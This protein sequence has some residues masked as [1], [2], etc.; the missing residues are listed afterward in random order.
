MRNNDRDAD[1][2]VYIK[3]AYVRYFDQGGGYKIRPVAVVGTEP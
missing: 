3:R 2:V 1:R